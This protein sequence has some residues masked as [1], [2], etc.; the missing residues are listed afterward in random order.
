M[1]SELVTQ[2]RTGRRA[3]ATAAAAAADTTLATCQLRTSIVS[4]DHDNIQLR[5][6]PTSTT[7]R[8]AFSS[9]SASFS[10]INSRCTD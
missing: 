10:A 9:A 3:S 8:A 5:P 6:H 7:S 4:M 1:I 2:V